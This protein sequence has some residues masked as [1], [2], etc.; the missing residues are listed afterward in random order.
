MIQVVINFKW[1]LPRVWVRR[2]ERDYP[3]VRKVREKKKRVEIP[4]EQINIFEQ[5]PETLC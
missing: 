1:P 4:V 5:T 2:M 3:P